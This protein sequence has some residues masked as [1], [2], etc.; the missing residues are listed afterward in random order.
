MTIQHISLDFWNTLAISNPEFAKARD[1]LI[2]DRLACSVEAVGKARRDV[3]EIADREANHGLAAEAPTL[4]LEM[5]RR[6][7]FDA[8]GGPAGG[9]ETLQRDVDRLFIEHPPLVS[10]EARLAIQGCA[11]RGLS[12]S[13]GSNT[14]FIRGRVICEALL[15]AYDLTFA[16]RV[17]SDEVRFAKPHKRFWDDVAR[18]ADHQCGASRREV[19]HIGDHE[20]CDGGCR[21]YGIQFRH[22]GGPAELAETLEGIR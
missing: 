8:G 18:Q 13:L 17:F 2:A 20:I 9:W 4:F 6:I 21:Q 15:R 11:T 10:D 12:L 19:I 22:V 14:N 5:M 16:Y 1:A 3:K 7:G